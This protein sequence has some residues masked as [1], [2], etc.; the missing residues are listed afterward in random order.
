MPKNYRSTLMSRVLLLFISQT[1]FFN[2][3]IISF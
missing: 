3:V 1:Q 2:I